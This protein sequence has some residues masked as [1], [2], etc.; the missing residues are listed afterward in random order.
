M[1]NCIFCKIARG[2]IPSIRIWENDRFYSFLDANPINPGHLLIIPKRHVD[3]F[4]DLSNQEYVEIMEIARKIEGSLKKTTGAKR[5]GLIVNGFEIPHA[6]LHLIPL[7]N[8]NDIDP[9]RAKKGIPEEMEKMAERI[10]LEIGRT[11]K[12]NK[13]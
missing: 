4:F 3:Y 7:H 1:E 10:R 9:R 5:I 6:H 8:S 2:E 11:N 13:E 12:N